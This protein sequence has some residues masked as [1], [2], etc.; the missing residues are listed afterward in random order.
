MLAGVPEAFVYVAQ[1]EFFASQ[2]PDGLKSLGM[3]LSMSSSAMGI[4]VE[5]AILAVVMKTTSKNGKPGW[6]A[7]TLNDG[8]LDRF[9]FVSAALAAL[10][11]ALYVLCAKRYKSIS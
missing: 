5:T 9:F 4:Y 7:P 2:T 11:F 6:V 3:G 8:H 1:M 10:N